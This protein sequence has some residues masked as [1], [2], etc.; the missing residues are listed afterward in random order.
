M[1]LGV[2]I[3]C[4]GMRMSERLRPGGSPAPGPAYTGGHAWVHAGEVAQWTLV[5]LGWLWLG[6]QGMRLGWSTASGVLA[7]VVWWAARVLS[8]GRGWALQVPPVGMGLFGLFTA[9]GV[10][11][12]GFLSDHSAAHASLLAVAWLWGVWCGVVETRSQ[13]S[14]FTL[15]PVAWHSLVAAMGAYLTWS[16]Q[17]QWLWGP[18][19]L[20]AVL[21]LCAAVLTMRDRRVAWRHLVSRGVQTRGPQVLP[22][23][24]MGLMMG[25]LWQ[26]KLWCL[27]LNLSLP[28]MVAAHLA[29]M[30][31]LLVGVTG[32]W[33]WLAPAGDAA[34]QVRAH[35]IGLACLALWPLMLLSDTVIQGVLAM[36]LPSLAW[37]LHVGRQREPETHRVQ[38]SSEAMRGLALLLGPGLLVWVGGLRPWLGPVALQSAVTLLGLLSAVHLLH[39]VGRGLPPWGHRLRSKC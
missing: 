9:W 21:T 16:T 10:W 30:A 28:G 25:S 20:S 8:C 19:G 18:W 5:W 12:P 32:L 37:A 31:G 17:A 29:L 22:A 35:H 14:T 13:S 39:V 27:G 15:A 33:R 34:M 38:G 24:G 2:R 4:T 3:N 7:V 11:W 6:E 1:P 26:S 23:A 36:L